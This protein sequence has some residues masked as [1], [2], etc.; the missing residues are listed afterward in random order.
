M[1][2]EESRQDNPDVS[3]AFVGTGT[4]SEPE[5]MSRIPTMYGIAGRTDSPANSSKLSTLAPIQSEILQLPQIED[6]ESHTTGIATL[7]S[8]SRNACVQSLGLERTFCILFQLTLA[9]AA[10]STPTSQALQKQANEQPSLKDDAAAFA[11]DKPPMQEMTR[12]VHEKCDQ[13]QKITFEGK[14]MYPID[15][16]CAII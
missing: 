15:Y 11:Q 4:V 14:A 12:G 16:L 1:H 9:K 8:K 6:G 7:C 5:D 2:V 10:V 3:D 13:P